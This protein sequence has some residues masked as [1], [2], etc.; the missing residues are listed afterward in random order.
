MGRM[1][2]KTSDPTPSQIRALCAKV[3]EGWDEE[4]IR[5]RVTGE[6]QEEHWMPPIVTIDGGEEWVKDSA[7][8]QQE[9]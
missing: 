1:G 9:A 5:K 2:H 7:G 8:H 6:R 4:E 3:R